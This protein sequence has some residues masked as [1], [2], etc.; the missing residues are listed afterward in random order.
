M[1]TT[2][3]GFNMILNVLIVDGGVMMYI[4]DIVFERLVVCTRVEGRSDHPGLSSLGMVLRG[5]VHTISQS[6]PVWN[7]PVT[8]S[9]GM[10]SQHHTHTRQ[11]S[12]SSS[13]KSIFNSQPLQRI[14]L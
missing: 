12:S 13:S 6:A 7:G 4:L 2:A 11:A 3:N 9:L 5:I 10:V 1:E 14:Q 8:G